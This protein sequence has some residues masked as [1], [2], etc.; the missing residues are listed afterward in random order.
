MKRRF[1]ILADSESGKKECAWCHEI[2][3]IEDFTKR[4]AA[5][6]G[7]DSACKDCRRPGTQAYY[8]ANRQTFIDKAVQWNRERENA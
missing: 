1:N 8:I 7:L 5:R 3:L 4:S 6:D 2:K